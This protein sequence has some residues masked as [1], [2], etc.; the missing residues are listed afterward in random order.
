MIEKAVEIEERYEVVS[1]LNGILE[2]DEL[3]SIFEEG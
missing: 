3:K 2:R 1:Y